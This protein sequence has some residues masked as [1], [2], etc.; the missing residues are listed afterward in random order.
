MEANDPEGKQMP[1]NDPGDQQ[2]LGDVERW[3][4]R[5]RVG[6]RPEG[7]RSP[8]RNTRFRDGPPDKEGDENEEERVRDV[9]AAPAVDAEGLWADGVRVSSRRHDV[10]RASA[11][12]AEP[13]DVVADAELTP[14]QDSL[15]RPP[16]DGA[17][18]PDLFRSGAEVEADPLQPPVDA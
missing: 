5:P 13:P 16:D 10:N 4:P 18:G 3:D 6:L 12:D 1:R 2:K 14:V 7:G 15:A 9:H 8:R 17:A 11:I